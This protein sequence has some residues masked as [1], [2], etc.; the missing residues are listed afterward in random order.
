MRHGRLA[1]RGR[2]RLAR[3]VRKATL[4]NKQGTNREATRN[5]QGTN[6][7]PTGN[8]SPGRGEGST[9][10]TTKSAMESRYS[11]QNSRA[12]RKTGTTSR[13]TA[14]PDSPCCQLRES[15]NK[16]DDG[17]R[18]CPTKAPLNACID[19]GSENWRKPLCTAAEVPRWS[20]TSTSHACAMELRLRE[21]VT[22]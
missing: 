3:T 2:L 13:Y 8:Q 17:A 10:Q 20:S 5:Q 12:Q 18:R 16:L 1:F 21:G 15:I 4:P 14:Q 22:I 11:Q 7:R 6:K 19:K 9:Y